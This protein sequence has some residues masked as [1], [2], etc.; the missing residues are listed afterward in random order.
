[1]EIIF[2]PHALDDLNYWKQKHDGKTLQRIRLPIENIQQNPFS[3]LA[4][5]EPLKY[6]LTGMW[7]RRINHS[8]G[9]YMKLLV[10]QLL[11]ML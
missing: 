9:W 4:K 1:M 11:Y 7:S 2:S 3:V 10:I 8:I 6:N 5:P